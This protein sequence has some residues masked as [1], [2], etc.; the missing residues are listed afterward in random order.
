MKRPLLFSVL[1]GLSSS[2][3]FSITAAA[4]DLEWSGLYRVE[5]YHI[6]NSE[7]N[8]TGRE[9]NYGLHHLILRPKIVAADGLTIYSQFNIFNHDINDPRYGNSQIG[10]VWGSGIGGTGASN[11]SRDSDSLAENQKAETIQVTQ[12][13]LTYVQEFGQLLVGRAPLHFGL[14]MTYNAGRGLFDH[15]YDTRDLLAYKIVMGNLSLMPMVGKVDEGALN[16]SDDVTDWMI[17]LQYQNPDTDL[18]MG[19]FYQ[20]RKAGDQG[21]D[22]P[23][24][25][26]TGGVIGGAGALTNRRQ[27]TTALSLYALKDTERM[28][29]GV[30]AS[31]LDGDTGVTTATGEKVGL[32][33]FGLA[34]EF[35]YRPEQSPW[36]MGLK[37]GMASGDD[38]TSDGEFE[39]FI[40]D[41]NYDVAFL[42][43]NHPLGQR[44]FL[45]T[46]LIGGGPNNAGQVESADTEA[47]SNVIYASPYAYYQWKERWGLEG[48]LTSGWLQEDP[49]TG[50][51]DN[52]LGYEFDFA[53]H[54][55]PKEGVTWINQIGLLFPGSAF[56]GDGSL[57]SKFMYGVTTKAAISF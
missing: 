20:A 13:Y 47:I 10:Q 35:E 25:T 14:G 2:L 44:D 34:A 27:S 57:E 55:R 49:L 51:K 12:L 8:D 32:S 5:G 22:T 48:T 56:E 6:K 33:G 1:L 42:M 15:W 16:A 39:G 18:E 24:G 46:G 45:R 36:K 40:F 26:T 11:T 53:V 28:R 38:P 19:V 17:Q 31:F 37:A 54:F 7:L 43:F 21:N 41:R 9:K 3:G 30:E 23:N 29:L 50:Q 52:G 4:G